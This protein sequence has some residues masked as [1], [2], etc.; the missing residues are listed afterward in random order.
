MPV[1]TPIITIPT[2]PLIPPS[3]MTANPIPNAKTRLWFKSGTTVCPVPLAPR[4]VTY[5]GMENE[6]VEEP[7]P[8][9]KSTL[10]NRAAKLKTVEM[11]ILYAYRNPKKTV[12]H[13]LNLIKKIASSE[14][15]VAIHYDDYTKGLWRCT[16]FS[17]ASIERHPDTNAITRATVDIGF[18]E[19]V[20]ANS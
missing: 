17:I 4:E 7:R 10:V 8:G 13:D 6:W 2:V 1:S 20:Y 19:L 12:T 18:T 11:T 16:S 9:R 5:G 14:L 15:P 3:E